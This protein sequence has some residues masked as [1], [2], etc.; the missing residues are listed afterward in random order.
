MS[1]LEKWRNRIALVVDDSQI[2]RFV[3]VEYLKEVGF[4]Q[5]YE[6]AD[7]KE[8]L[9]I[10]QTLEQVDFILTDLSMPGMDG[11]ELLGCLAKASKQYF[12][13]VMSAVPRDVLDAVQGIADASSLELLAVMPKPL[14]LESICKLLEKSDPDLHASSTAWPLFNFSA[15]DVAIAIEARELHLYF[16]PKVT[17]VDKKLIGFEALARWLHPIHGVLP[18]IAFIHHVEHGELALRFFYD[19][20]SASCDMLKTLHTVAD[21]IHCSI[22]LPVPLL[23]RAELVD[24]MQAIVEAKGVDSRFIIVEVTE[25]TL[26]SN[27]AT[28][29]GALARLRIKGFGVAMDDYGTGYSSMKQLSRCPFTEIKI[30]KEFVH[31]AVHSQKKL[32]ILTSA[33]SMSQRLNLKVVAEGVETEEDWNQLSA[34][35]CDIAQGY[36][37]SRPIPEEKVLAWIASWQSQ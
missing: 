13:S 12:I 32:A 17:I 31:G 28:F 37:I 25:T 7:G 16:Q 1:H 6:A 10:L 21:G 33:I 4:A 8:A 5:V 18:P 11:I 3:A 29:L 20:L 15:D 24:A 22:N 35:G 23:D 19:L 34:L 36:F 26:M 9:D 30:D 2:H 14:T 27:L